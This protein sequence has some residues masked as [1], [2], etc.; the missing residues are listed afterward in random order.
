RPFT[1][2]GEQVMV[3]VCPP[4]AVMTAVAVFV[5]AVPYVCDTP[6]PVLVA[7]LKS[8]PVQEYVE[9]L[10]AFVTV[11]LEELSIKIGFGEAAQEMLDGSPTVTVSVFETAPA[12]LV[13]DKVKV[14]VELVRF[15][16]VAVE[17]DVLEMVFGELATLSLQLM[18]GDEPAVPVAE[19]E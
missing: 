5:P 17:R 19:A 9:P 15:E 13:Q 8:V 1:V 12:L 16:T 18:A 14:C 3:A 10:G 4:E 6:F 11:Q 7:G 2:K